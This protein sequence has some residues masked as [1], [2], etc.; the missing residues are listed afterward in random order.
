MS[1]QGWPRPP[2]LYVGLC[3]AQIPRDVG[4]QILH[5]QYHT[6]NIYQGHTGEYHLAK[7]SP[8]PTQC[9]NFPHIIIS[10]LKISLKFCLNS[11]VQ[12]EDLNPPQSLTYVM[13]GSSSSR[14]ATPPPGGK[15]CCCCPVPQMIVSSDDDIKLKT[16]WNEFNCTNIFD[17]CWALE[18]DPMTRCSQLEQDQSQM[19]R[20]K[21]CGGSRSQFSSNFGT[22]VKLFVVRPEFNR[23]IATLLND[24]CQIYC[25][26]D[27]KRISVVSGFLSLLNFLIW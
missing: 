18:L 21:S 15:L 2:S 1:I 19:K 26:Y 22:I 20:R 16:I 10:Q 27:S 7:K 14:A 3:R 8:E 9:I 11:S 6:L 5:E 17:C 25:C 4:V 24:F 12:E 13:V 23:G